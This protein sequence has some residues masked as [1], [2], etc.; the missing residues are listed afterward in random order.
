MRKKKHILIRL[1]SSLTYF[2]WLLFYFIV[3]SSFL[4]IL[5]FLSLSLAAH[6]VPSFKLVYTQVAT[7]FFLFL[8][9][10]RDCCASVLH[11]VAAS[12]VYSF[13]SPCLPQPLPSFMFIFFLSPLFSYR[14]HTLSAVESR[15]QKKA[16]LSAADIYAFSI[17]FFFCACGL[18]T[19]V[20]HPVLSFSLSSTHL[21]L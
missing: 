3:F 9:L 18:D 2:D 11:I 16:S 20:S 13:Y 21:V 14:K 8:R 6:P 19:P 4:I 17:F 5:F 7:L 10:L 1:L 12:Q 15:Q